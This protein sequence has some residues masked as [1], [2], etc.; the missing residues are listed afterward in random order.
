[1][2]TPTDIAEIGGLGLTFSTLIVGGLIRLSVV[3]TKQS[4]TISNQSDAIKE[5]KENIKPLHDISDRITSTENLLRARFC[6][7]NKPDEDGSM[8][9]EH[10]RVRPGRY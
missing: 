3:I 5:L 2:I 9:G 8:S 6:P 4:M 7:W 10:R 1:M